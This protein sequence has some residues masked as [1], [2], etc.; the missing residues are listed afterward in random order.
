MSPCPMGK[1]LHG[2]YGGSSPAPPQPRGLLSQQDPPPWRCSH[3]TICLYASSAS[4]K[5]WGSMSPISRPL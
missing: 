5:M 1:V 2:P 4:A 3:L